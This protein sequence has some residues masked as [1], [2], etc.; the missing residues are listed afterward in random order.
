MDT[1]KRELECPTEDLPIPKK[2]QKIV[3]FQTPETEKPATSS[4]LSSPLAVPRFRKDFCD[5]LKAQLG[6]A[7]SPAS[8]I[9]LLENDGSSKHRVYAPTKEVLYCSK[10]Q[11]TLLKALTSSRSQPGATSG[12]LTYERLHLAKDLA[13]A[14][15]QYHATPWMSISWRSRDIYLFNKDDEKADWQNVNLS[16]LHVNVKVKDRHAHPGKSRK[17]PP[18]PLKEMPDQYLTGVVA[19]KASAQSLAPNNVLFSLGVTLLELA[20]SSDLR[21]LRQPCDLE[22]ARDSQY[23]EFF[24]A[25]RLASNAIREMGGTYSNIVKKL[26]QCN[27]GCG[28]DLN[29]LEL[30][31]LFYKDVVCE[32]DRLE[33]A[34]RELCVGVRHDRLTI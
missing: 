10:S 8:C 13:I 23:T 34:F 19:S 4:S 12:L 2:S 14:V 5:I 32:L 16:S 21:T 1:L 6:S 9:G 11:T 27:F 28:D 30:Q 17:H 22:N 29:D 20:Y 33:Q 3:R 15:L 7:C 18:R 25:K 26:L 24:I 31:V